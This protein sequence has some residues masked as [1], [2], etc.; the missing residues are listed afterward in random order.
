MGVK[1][2]TAIVASC[3]RCTTSLLWSSWLAATKFGWFILDELT[4]CPDCAHTHKAKPSIEVLQNRIDQ[5]IGIL[6]GE[7]P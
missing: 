3:D 5:C 1:N 2:V 4:L 6:K 7:T